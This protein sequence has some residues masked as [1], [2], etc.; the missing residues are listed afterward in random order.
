MIFMR[1]KLALAF[2]FLFF[3][4]SPNAKASDT[5]E[6]LLTCDD[7]ITNFRWNELCKKG[8]DVSFM[9]DYFQGKF[10]NSSYEDYRT[11]GYYVARLKIPT[12]EESGKTK[13]EFYGEL[14]EMQYLGNVNF[15]NGLN[16][17]FIYSIYV[18]FMIF[19]PSVADEEFSE[20][21][22]EDNQR[23]GNKTYEGGTTFSSL[24]FKEIASLFSDNCTQIMRPS[25]LSFITNNNNKPYGDQII[26]RES[27]DTILRAFAKIDREGRVEDNSFEEWF[28]ANSIENNSEIEDAEIEECPP[29]YSSNIWNNCYGTYAFENGD[30]YVGQFKNDAFNGQGNYTYS[31][32]QQYIGDF[33]NGYFD[34]HGTQFYF[35][36]DVYV[37]GWKNDKKHGQGAYN[38]NNGAKY[39]GEWQNDK[40]H[41]KGTY[42]WNNNDLFLGEWQNDKKHGQG[43]LLFANGAS[44]LGEWKE[45][46]RHGFGIYTF[47]DGF[48]IQGYFRNDQYIPATCLDLGFDEGSDDFE[49]CV[50]KLINDL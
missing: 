17:Y 16:S 4:F 12:Y 45:D 6:A 8:F 38:Y 39:V 22:F 50:N 20:F 44:Y 3:T 35:D 1:F 11:C 9:V 40:K 32:G 48:R 7:P 43:T 29:D 5:Q 26:I 24:T 37:G 28:F 15:W 27:Q 30:V 31:N 18:P 49:N 19:N 2:C 25:Y 41:G 13:E 14:D 34:G 46:M 21:I 23:I 47:D 33:K 42:Y 10:N 36:G